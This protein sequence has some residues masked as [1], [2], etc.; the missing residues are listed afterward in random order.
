[1]LGPHIFGRF[2]VTRLIIFMIFRQ[3]DFLL[4]VEILLMKSETRC[5]VGIVLFLA[6]LA[7]GSADVDG[8]SRVGLES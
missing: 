6:P 8:V 3:S 1:M 5:F 4:A 2:P 7:I